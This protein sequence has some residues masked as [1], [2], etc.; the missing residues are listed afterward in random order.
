MFKISL[1]ALLFILSKNTKEDEKYPYSEWDEKTKMEANSA[2]DIEYYS[3]TEKEVI[4]L[5][6]LARLNG[7]LFGQTYLQEYIDNPEFSIKKMTYLTSLQSDLKKL[8]SKGMKALKPQE[9]LYNSAKSHAELQG[10]K[11][12]TG[13]QNYDKRFKKF[14]P[15]YSTTGENCD[16][17]N[18]TALEIVMHLLIDE[19]VSDKGHRKNI[20]NKTFLSVGL[21]IQNH[22]KYGTCCVMDFGDKD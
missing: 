12:L 20:L 5:M 10:K 3:E 22:K 13:H 19:D 18:D 1:F 7:K 17:G 2:L 11:G 4:Y 9:D 6:N 8:K 21:S 16:Y 15:R 14:A